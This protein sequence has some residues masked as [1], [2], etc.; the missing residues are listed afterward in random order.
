VQETGNVVEDEQ[1]HVF[2]TLRRTVLLPLW[3]FMRRS[4]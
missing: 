1:T 2:Q 4:S 3:K